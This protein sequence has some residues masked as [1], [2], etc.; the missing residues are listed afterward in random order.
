[1]VRE[2]QGNLESGCSTLSLKVREYC[3][4]SF[5]YASHLACE[6]RNVH[7]NVKNGIKLDGCRRCTY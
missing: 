7:K 5:L 3:I 1:M 2:Q 4:Y 6:V